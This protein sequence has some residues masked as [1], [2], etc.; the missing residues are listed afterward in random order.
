M[1]DATR[2]GARPGCQWLCVMLPTCLALQQDILPLGEFK[3]LRA[4]ARRRGL[5]VKSRHGPTEL[6]AQDSS[7][8]AGSEEV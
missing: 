1:T 3:N 6:A 7:C 8:K 4:W 5:R 2:M